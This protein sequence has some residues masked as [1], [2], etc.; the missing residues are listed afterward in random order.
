M[1]EMWVYSLGWEDPLEKEMATHS[2]I[3]AWKILWTEEP[4]GLQFT[5]PQKSRTEFSDET[6]TFIYIYTHTHICLHLYFW[7]CRMTT[8]KMEKLLLTLFCSWRN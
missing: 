3:L 6:M 4:H 1:E 2:C 8:G 5:G 7:F